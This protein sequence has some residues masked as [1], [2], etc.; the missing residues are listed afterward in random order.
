[1]LSDWA[2]ADRPAGR[3]ARGAQ[4]AD[5][6][7]LALLALVARGGARAAAGQAHPALLR[8]HLGAPPQLC[9][10]RPSLD[11]AA[12]LQAARLHASARAQAARLL[13]VCRSGRALHRRARDAP[14]ARGLPARGVRARRRAGVALDL[15]HH[16][17][18]GAGHVA[19][20]Q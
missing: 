11:D 12:R 4:A 1:M 7:D 20:R 13:A 5:G 14:D 8:V 10:A 15:L 6:F 3:D 18:R 2:L 19:G 9:G 17:R 16:A